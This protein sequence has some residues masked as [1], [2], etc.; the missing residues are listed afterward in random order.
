MNTAARSYLT[1]G[2]ALVGAGAIAV[3]PVAPPIP[4]AEPVAAPV[5]A[6]AD[7]QLSALANP[8]AVYGQV[9]ENTLENLGLLGERILDDPAPILAQILRNQWSSAETLMGALDRAGESLANS[10]SADNPF[11]VPALLRAAGDDF[12]AGDLEGAINN[13]WQVAITPLL[14]PAVELIPAINAVIRQPVQ[15]MLNVI[16]QTQLPI[17]LFA[18]GVLSPI[19]AGAVKAGGAF[20]QDVFDAVRTGDLEGLANAFITGPAAMIDGFLNGDEI[21]AGFLSPGLG[22]IS[23]LLNIRDAIAN[24][25]KPPS[26]AG[27]A[28][29][30]STT[31]DTTART[32]SVT[33]EAQAEES[34][35]SGKDPEPVAKAAV[36]DGDSTNADVSEAAEEPSDEVT[37]EEVTDED[38]TDEEPSDEEVTDEEVTD[39]EVTDEEVTDD[40]AA[41]DDDSDSD[42][43]A[44]TGGDSDPGSDANS[45]SGSDSGTTE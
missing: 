18:I 43:A 27:I 45:D 19:Y 4:A 37:D 26:T 11:G 42:S 40:E 31:T 23:G 16:D 41:A 21:D 1:T 20:V 38:V 9:F 17:T 30:D 8:F 6:A 25:L 28:A 10:F 33:V 3:S 12:A 13:L 39:D 22:T 5:V 24:A 32:V 7:L 36:L 2:V 29:I 44:D 14:G 15:N 35:G 34:E